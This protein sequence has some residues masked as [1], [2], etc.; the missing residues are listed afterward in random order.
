[1]RPGTKGSHRLAQSVPEIDE[2]VV[3]ARPHG[4]KH[5]ASP[6]RS[7]PRKLSVSGVARYRR[8]FV[9]LIPFNESIRGAVLETNISD[10]IP[11]NLSSVQKAIDDDDTPWRHR[12]RY[13][14]NARGLAARRN[15]KRLDKGI[16]Q[17]STLPALQKNHV[18]LTPTLRVGVLAFVLNVRQIAGGCFHTPD[19]V[20]PRVTPDAATSGAAN[21][22]RGPTRYRQHASRC[23]QLKNSCG[24]LIQ[25]SRLA[26]RNSRCSKA[27]I[28]AVIYNGTM[29]AS[30]PALLQTSC[31]TV[32]KAEIAKSLPTAPSR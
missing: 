26:L 21:V 10:E 15:C 4:L 13:E 9:S 3:D 22:T 28:G 17:I 1:M 23:P 14:L 27:N 31:W 6:S 25:I 19:G 18:T 11:S 12:E 16:I 20:T 2:L 29:S 32:A 5:G 8:S 24:I 7:M 30:G